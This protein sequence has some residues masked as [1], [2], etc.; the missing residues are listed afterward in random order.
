MWETLINLPDKLPNLVKDI[1]ISSLI[2]VIGYFLLKVT[3][4]II[5]RQLRKINNKNEHILS[6]TFLKILNKFYVI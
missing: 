1:T 4:N 3:R 5:F 2:L 6:L